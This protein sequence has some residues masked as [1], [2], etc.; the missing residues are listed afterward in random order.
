EAVVLA[1]ENGTGTQLVAYL[2]A[3]QD[4]PAVADLKALLAQDLPAF[5]V[6]AQWLFL[7]QLPLTPNGKLDRKALPQPDSTQAQT[8]HVAPVTERERQLAAIWADVLKVEKVGMSDDFF[9]LGGHSL[10]AVQVLARIRDQLQCEIALRELFEKS[11]LADL[12]E[13]V[14]QKQGQAGSAQ[15]ELTKSLEALKRLSAEEIDNLIA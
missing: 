9:D 1:K 14:E 2:V 10:L 8:A 15:D 7:D 4:Q 3:D 6:P 11:T 13:V 5:M 12:C